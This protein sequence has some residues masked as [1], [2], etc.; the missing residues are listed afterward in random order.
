MTHRPSLLSL[1]VE[2]A[3][4]WLVLALLFAYTSALFF[5]APYPGFGFTPSR[6][7]IKTV[8][9]TSPPDASLQDG[10]QFIQIGAVSWTDFQADLRQTLFENVRPGQVVPITIERNDE[11]QTIPWVFPGPTQAEI[12]YRLNSNWFL[13]YIFWLA[14][15]TTLLFLRPKDTRWRLLI[16]FNFLTAIWLTAGSVSRWHLWESAIVLRGVVW[17]SMPVYWHLHWIFP[18]PL[19]RLPTKAW[20]LAYLIAGLLAIA[21]WFQLLPTQAYFVG[22]AL[23]LAGSVV[24]LVIHFILQPT[25]RRDVG[26]LVLAVILVLAPSIAISIAGSLNS[27]PLNAPGAFLTLPILPFAYLY[28]TY[29]RQLGGLELRTNRF[30]A[31]YIY[32]TLLGGLLLILI[33]AAERWLN[34]TG[35][36][37]FIGVVAALLAA[38][39]ATISLGPFQRFIEHRVLGIPLPPS[40]LLQAYAA[41]ITVS[42]DSQTLVSLLTK[43]ILPSLLIRQSALLR[44]AEGKPVTFYTNGVT[45]DQL[46]TG[47]DLRDLLTQTGKYRAST[48]AGL[49]PCPWVR[50]ILLL[51]IEQKPI[52]LWLLGRRDP[53][54]FYAQ[55]EI[56][57]LQ[58]LAHQTAIALVNI[59]QAERLHALYQ[60]DIDRVETQR[61]NLARELHD[62]VL[63]QLAVLKTSIDENNTQP[64][65]LKSYETVVASLRQTIS[66]LRPALL[67]YGLVAA[68]TDLT[69]ALAERYENEPEIV[70]DLPEAGARYDPQLEQH[71]YRIIQQAC[72][73]ALQHAQPRTIK[74]LGQL[75]AGQI[76]LTVEDDGIG[77]HSDAQLDLARL[78]TGKHFGLAGM[79]ERAALVNAQV[80]IDSAPGR[81]TRVRV[82]WIA[83][84]GAS[85]PDETQVTAET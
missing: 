9:V 70:L 64:R 25:Q 37:I 78:A 35:E 44:L 33:A 59:V 16:A 24:L 17:L 22:L 57:L 51:R 68:L 19:G 72:E 85:Q 73:N 32:F 54:D 26:L 80:Q 66:G 5:Q 2:P 75:E 18:Q 27:L 4:P 20:S 42:L 31:S 77:F 13:G 36:A 28:A 30:I 47:E 7:S 71:I 65:F 43:E 60:T 76:D 29:R 74:I 61:A 63:N 41:R 12:R 1:L 40:Q 84:Y 14:G 81:G 46:P 34:F 67:N 56:D 15:T 55:A 82:T 6:G 48:E 79:F 21:E 83:S 8:F 58:L 52:G 53:D 3:L 39:I 23:G 11:S 69:D 45:A 62:N 49:R 38:L 50:L 10:D